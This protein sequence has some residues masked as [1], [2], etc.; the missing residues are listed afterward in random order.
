MATAGTGKNDGNNP[1]KGRVMGQSALE[2][3]RLCW[4]LFLTPIKERLAPKLPLPFSILLCNTVV[5]AG[6]TYLCF[7]IGFGL[8]GVAS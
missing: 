8:G 4:T 6:A 1:L 7:A 3:P 5:P 2:F